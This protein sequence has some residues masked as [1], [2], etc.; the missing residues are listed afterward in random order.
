M[1]WGDKIKQDMICR[2]LRG[3][4]TVLDELGYTEDEK[5]EIIEY[6][7]KRGKKIVRMAKRLG[8]S[9]GKMTKRIMQDVK[10][11]GRNGK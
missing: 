10:V 3:D 5:K 11:G 4:E 9:A 8:K 1:N 6:S 2:I 7:E